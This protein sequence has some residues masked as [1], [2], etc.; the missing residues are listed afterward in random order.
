MIAH[1]SKPEYVHV[2]LNPPP[3]CGLAVGVLGL[4]IALLLRADKDNHAFII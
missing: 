1:P 3:V 2:L 4:V